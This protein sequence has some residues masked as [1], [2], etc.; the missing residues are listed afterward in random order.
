MMNSNSMQNKILFIRVCFKAQ[1]SQYYSAAY[2][3]ALNSAKRVNDE[4]AECDPIRKSKGIV[5]RVER[6][7]EGV[8]EQ[9]TERKR[10]KKNC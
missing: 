10:E 9:E 5:S 8:R 1:K 3:L 6:R 2:E 7:R 4:K